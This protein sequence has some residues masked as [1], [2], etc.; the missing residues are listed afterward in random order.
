MCPTSN[1]CVLL[2]MICTSG[3]CM[4]ARHAEMLAWSP[5]ACTHPLLQIPLSSVTK[6]GDRGSLTLEQGGA[7]S[8]CGAWPRGSG[9]S[10]SPGVLKCPRF[11]QAHGFRRG[12]DS[13]PHTSSHSR[14]HLSSPLILCLGQRKRH[15]SPER[16]ST[17]RG[18]WGSSAAPAGTHGLQHM[19]LGLLRG[20]GRGGH[21]SPGGLQTPRGDGQWARVPKDLGQGLCLV[22]T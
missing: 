8:R 11:P 16:D 17:G 4:T 19:L 7:G 5:G 10:T 12:F 13:R 9:L 20:Q 2:H 3:C 1:A 14:S 6:S 21:G 22:P 18:G 15:L